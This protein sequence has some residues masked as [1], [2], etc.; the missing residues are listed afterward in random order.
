MPTAETCNGKDDDCEGTTDPNGAAG[1]TVYHPDRDGDGFGDA[2]T[3]VCAC[4]KPAG[5]VLDGT[6][7]NDADGTILPGALET[8]F[9]SQDNDC[10]GTVDEGCVQGSCRALH[11]A[12]PELLSGTYVIDV[13][14]FGKM[15][16]YC[17][18]ATDDGGWTLVASYPYGSTPVPA[19]WSG[20]ASGVGTDY[21]GTDKLFEMPDDLINKLKS[22]GYR[23]HG[24]A[25]WCVDGACAL[26]ITWYFKPTCTFSSSGSTSAC[27]SAYK[28]AAFTQPTPANLNQAWCSWHWGLVDT[29]CGKYG[30][31]ITHHRPSDGFVVCVGRMDA[32]QHACNGRGSE[33]ASARIW[34]K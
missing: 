1:C 22:A 24:T 33:K 14:G 31:V 6:D 13:T 18:M 28:D 5:H 9:D 26:D 11:E 34:V 7:C 8:C 19:N 23:V 25:T 30:G 4:E 32:Y 21:T 2:N 12:H 3:S 17:D 29:W 16:V 20:S 10:D 27:A 15:T